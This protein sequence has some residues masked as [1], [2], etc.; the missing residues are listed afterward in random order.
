MRNAASRNRD[1][2]ARSDSTS[3]PTSPAPLTAPPQP[4]NPRPA[5]APAETCPTRNSQQIYSTNRQA[6]R[7]T[8]H[9]AACQAASAAPAPNGASAPPRRSPVAGARVVSD[10][11]GSPCLGG[12]CQMGVWCAGVGWRRCWCGVGS[13]AVVWRGCAGA[14]RV[15]VGRGSGAQGLSQ[16]PIA[17]VSSAVRARRGARCWRLRPAG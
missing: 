16:G 17:V 12:W 5:R 8:I 1:S 7:R 4:R 6:H 11:S 2:R 3:R 15:G 13:G 14:C 10:M 9:R